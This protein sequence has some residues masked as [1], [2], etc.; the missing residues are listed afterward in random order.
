[1][2]TVALDTG[3]LYGAVT[4]VGLSVIEVVAEF[5]RRP[6][7]IAIVPYAI[8]FRAPLLDGTRRLAYPAALAVRSWGRL[9]VPTANRA[10]R[11]ADLIHGTNFVVPP[12]RLP[13]LVTI[14]DCWALRHPEQCSPTINRAMRALRHAVA[15]GA[16][17]H[18][19]SHATAD[20]VRE[21]FPHSSVTVVPWATPSDIGTGSRR[22]D[23]ANWAP[24]TP[25][26][27]S[28]GTLDHRKN[29]VRLVE[30]FAA[31]ADEVPDLILAVAGAP[32]SAAL[33][34]AAAIDRVPPHQ[35]ARIVLLGALDH[36]QVNWLYQNSSVM[37]Y[38][39]LD[40]G[41]GF[42]VLEAMAASVPVVAAST[43]SLPEVAGDAALLVDPTDPHAL[44][45]AL[46]IALRDQE[47]RSELIAAG[48]SRVDHF[49]WSATADGLL[50]LYRFVVDS[51]PHSP[52]KSR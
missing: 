14:H 50:D 25:V 42:P 21:F 11:P 8:S 36:D 17:V 47:R 43:G 5:H 32:G 4:G 26:I 19:P 20:A 52:A 41:F 45:E 31:L 30:A 24:G 35:R 10:L 16:Y 51:S 12:S 28:V 44:A 13:R 49:S 2:L 1:M 48:L 23:L 3:P 37:A 7:D 18:V 6:E 15:T 33:T 38:P 40:E 46:G 9:S 27:A 34:V 29:V 39:S 22:P